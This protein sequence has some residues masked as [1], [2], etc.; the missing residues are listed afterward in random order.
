MQA[1]LPVK[2]CRLGIRRVASLVS[3][4]FFASAAS[5]RDRQSK[6]LCLTSLSS[7][8]VVISVIARWISISVFQCQTIHFPQN[9]IFEMRQSLLQTDYRSG[10]TWLIARVE[11]GSL[12]W[13]LLTVGTGRTSFQWLLAARDRTTRCGPCS[14]GL[15]SWRQSLRA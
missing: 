7:D 15:T 6:I 9:N 12:P 4:A 1:S 13:L 5:T 3:S 2:T 14:D 11:Q 10:W 8:L